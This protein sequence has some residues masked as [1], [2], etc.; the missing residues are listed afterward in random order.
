MNVS[1]MLLIYVPNIDYG[2]LLLMQIS[3]VPII[4]VWSKNKQKCKRPHTFTI[5]GVYGY[6]YCIDSY[7]NGYLGRFLYWEYLI[8]IYRKLIQ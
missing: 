1:S 7:C 4:Y 3:Q 2:C 8:P 5:G 6:T